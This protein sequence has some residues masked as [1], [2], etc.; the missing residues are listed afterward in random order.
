MH[1]DYTMLGCG[2]MPQSWNHDFFIEEDGTLRFL[3]YGS[4]AGPY[5]EDSIF[6]YEEDTVFEKVDEAE[7]PL[8]ALAEPDELRALR[9]GKRVRTE[10][11]ERR[12]VI[13]QFVEARDVL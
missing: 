9:G 11:G 1:C 7:A 5:S 2:T 10:D 6:S 3:S 8:V 13:S 12:D 4:G